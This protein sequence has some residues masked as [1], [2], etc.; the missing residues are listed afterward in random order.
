MENQSVKR[1]F[2]HKLFGTTPNDG[3]LQ[4][5]EAIAYSITGIGQNFIC[6]IIGSYLTIFMT[7]ALLMA[8]ARQNDRC[9]RSSASYA[10]HEGV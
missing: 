6:T 9:H 3:N 2:W 4:P 10:L 7:D 8:D 1:G 5:R